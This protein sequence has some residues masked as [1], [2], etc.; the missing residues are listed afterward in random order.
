MSAR[1]RSPGH[2]P[3]AAVLGG[4]VALSCLAAAPAGPSGPSPGAAPSDI[5]FREVSQAWGLHYRHRSGGSG[6]FF[7][8]E[9]MASGVVVFDYDG[10]GD[11]D[12]FLAGAGVL[13]GYTGPPPRSALFRNDGGHFVDV[14][15]RAGIDV[16]G[17][18]M[19]AVAGDVDSDGDRDLFVASF[20]ANQLFEN[21]GDGTFVD[22]TEHAGLGDTSYGS[23]AAFG[24]VDRDGDLDLY[25]SNYVDFTVDNN[26]VCGNQA[27][28]IRTYCHPDIFGALHDLFYLN[29]GD[30]TFVDATEA[31]GFGD[32]VGK[33]FSAVFADID[34]DGWPDLY[35]ANDM[36]PNFLFH[37]L[38]VGADGRA[39]FEDLGLLSGTAYNDQGLTEAGMGIAIGDLDGDQR[40]EIMVTHMDDQTNALY[41][42]Q[43]SWIFT[44]HRFVDGLA[45]PSVGLVGFGVAFADFDQDG[46]LDV[47]VANGH[48]IRDIEKLVEGRTYAQRNQVF[49]NRG[50]GKLA[51]VE[52]S[53]LDL[54]R[55]SRGL[56]VSDF[57]GDGDLDMVINDNDDF[58]EV[59]ENVSPDPGAWLQ[60]D[61]AQSSG[62][63]FAVGG[64][65][66]VQSGRAAPQWREV[67]TA[68]SYLSEDS[69]TVHFGL[70][71]GA[72]A[73]VDR[74]EI[75]WPDGTTQAVLGVPADRRLRVVR[76]AR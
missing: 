68:S 50:D 30:G 72:P 15:D 16:T 26:P 49:E 20:G 37:N 6:S 19:G 11:D 71:K 55:V 63:R 38:G 31:S 44:D 14:T 34:E 24:D 8:P 66:T 9:T 64:R 35:V 76:T 61:L 54:V 29:R 67:R 48:I 23:G 32:A 53:G 5:R 33:G 45:E 3:L 12:V 51:E 36:T 25:V 17:Y 74:L 73:A 4:L 46:D 75:R 70:G 7:M 41:S 18:A 39:T 57:D 40:P 56:A 1:R 43:G 62:N 65:V 27:R 13:P 42:Y 58:A 69:L 10:D 28:G 59:Y 2:G 60:V 22:A 47:A 52:D 21:R